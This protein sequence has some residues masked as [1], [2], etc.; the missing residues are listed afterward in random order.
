VNTILLS[1]FLEFS[2]DG[3]L[4]G[5]FDDAIRQNI[6]FIDCV[7]AICVFNEMRVIGRFYFISAIADIAEAVTIAQ[8]PPSA[9]EST[10]EQMTATEG[11]FRAAKHTFT[12]PRDHDFTHE[13]IKLLDYW[14]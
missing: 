4:L 13:A 10:L 5:W 7:F 2:V 3:V 1:D 12:I 9:I 8:I 6:E 14:F 11:H